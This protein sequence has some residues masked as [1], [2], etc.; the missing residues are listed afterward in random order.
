MRSPQTQSK[1]DSVVSG[2]AGELLGEGNRVWADVGGYVQP[3]LVFGYIPDI[4]AIKGNQNLI[5]EVEPLDTYSSEHTKDQLKA[6]DLAEN[7]LL[8]V[9]VPKSAFEAAVVEGGDVGSKTTCQG[10]G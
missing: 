9:V 3:Q 1:H 4:I 7:Y 8:E 5:S 10:K 6:F 2:R